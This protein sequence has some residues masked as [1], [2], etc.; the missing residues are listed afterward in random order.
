VTFAPT[1]Y[2][3]VWEGKL[4]IETEEN[5]WSFLVNGTLPHYDPPVG[6]SSLSGSFAKK[7][8]ER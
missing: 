5:Y 1:Q 6:K 8:T 2:R 3:N 4:V 7:I